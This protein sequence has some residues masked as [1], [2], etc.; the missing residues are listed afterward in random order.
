VLH[1]QEEL[2][3][4]LERHLEEGHHFKPLRT[5]VLVV[6]VCDSCSQNPGRKA[7]RRPTIDPD[8]HHFTKG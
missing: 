2:V 8:H 1:I 6:G 7:A 4:E 5:E 3:S